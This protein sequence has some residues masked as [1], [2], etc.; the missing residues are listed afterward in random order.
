MRYW[1]A[2]VYTP[3]CGE[4]ADVYIAAE[5]MREAMVKAQEAANE[6]GM[7]WFDEE[8]W[9]ER[10]HD[11]YNSIDDYY[12]QCGVQ[13]LDAITEDEYKYREEEGEWCV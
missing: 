3:F 2:R 1:H 9:L 12:A 8:D 5:T 7:E 13:Y 4:D 10:H 6:N 11:D